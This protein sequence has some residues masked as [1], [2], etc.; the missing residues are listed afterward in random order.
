MI[1][2]N[3]FKPQHVTVSKFRT[4]NDGRICARTIQRYIHR[5]R[6]RS[7]VSVS[8]PYLTTKHIEAVLHGL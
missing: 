6:I 1:E 2:S 4:A 3:L 5:A 7:Y 8:K